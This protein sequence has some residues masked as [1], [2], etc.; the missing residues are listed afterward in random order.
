MYTAAWKQ[1]PTMTE[2]QTVA[3]VYVILHTAGLGEI[4]SAQFS[5]AAKLRPA[6]PL[7]GPNIALALVCCCSSIGFVPYI[8]TPCVTAG[9]NG[10]WR[11]G[12]IVL[13]SGT[14]QHSYF[15]T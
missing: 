5:W 1:S 14:V 6:L 2:D 10:T 9:I 15:S 13:F 11:K 4:I 8:S 12:F 3:L 7:E